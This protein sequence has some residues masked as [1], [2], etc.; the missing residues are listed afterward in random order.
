MI[1]LPPMLPNML[2][3]AIVIICKAFIKL[4]LDYGGIYT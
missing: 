1:C 2:A 3:T 4:L